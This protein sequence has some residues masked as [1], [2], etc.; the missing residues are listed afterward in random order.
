MISWYTEPLEIPISYRGLSPQNNHARAGRTQWQERGVAGRAF[1]KWSINRGGPVMP[2]VRSR[3]ESMKNALPLYFPLLAGIALFTFPIFAQDLAIPDFS[4]GMPDV[5]LERKEKVN[6]Q[7]TFHLR[8]VLVSK[9]FST[10][11]SEFLGAGWRHRTLKREEMI[12][13]AER[14]RT[15]NATVNLSIYENA[16]LPGVDIRVLQLKPKKA[17]ADSTV[18]I[19]VMRAELD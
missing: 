16:K 14:A 4:K 3:N 8:T 7:E 12:L 5:N 17:G 1:F 2:D 11:L 10:A 19:T 18:E 9:E 13:S 15:S 6:D